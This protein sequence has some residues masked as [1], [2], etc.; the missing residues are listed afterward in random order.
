MAHGEGYNERLE[1]ALK[2]RGAIK[3]HTKDMAEGSPQVRR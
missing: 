1:K 3:L 2:R